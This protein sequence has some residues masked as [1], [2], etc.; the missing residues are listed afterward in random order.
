MGFKQ[1]NGIPGEDEKVLK[2]KGKSKTR[3]EIAK[4]TQTETDRQRE[5]ERQRKTDR[6]EHPG[7][8]YTTQRRVELVGRRVIGHICHLEKDRNREGQRR[9]RRRF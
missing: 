8:S 9:R 5:T 7:K 4:H 6:D 3:I 1:R 2:A